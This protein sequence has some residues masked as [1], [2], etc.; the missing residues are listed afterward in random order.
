[1]AACQTVFRHRHPPGG[2]CQQHRRGWAPSLKLTAV[3]EKAR[4]PTVGLT[5]SPTKEVSNDLHGRP[6]FRCLGCLL[7]CSPY[8]IDPTMIDC[9]VWLHH[10]TPVL[11]FSL[12]SK[13]V[14]QLCL[15]TI[16][17]AAHQGNALKTV[18]PSLPVLV[19]LRHISHNASRS[20]VLCRIRG[21]LQKR[22]AKI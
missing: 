5:S 6:K 12:A 4:A 3:A 16:L 1:M 19:S 21:S 15:L 10:F 18:S 9:T 14:C 11:R 17:S 8:H 13:A 22:S 7:S 20:A 2:H